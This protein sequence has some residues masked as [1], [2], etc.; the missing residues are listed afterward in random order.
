VTDMIVVID[1]AGDEASAAVAVTEDA[2]RPAV[3]AGPS[4]PTSDAGPEPGSP[5][6][7]TGCACRATG[8][9]Q[10]APSILAGVLAA[11]V[12]AFSRRTARRG[13]D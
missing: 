12:W 2:S 13:S 1:E 5:P 9:R 7:D 11:L 3:D 4:S 8:G 10:D 6:A